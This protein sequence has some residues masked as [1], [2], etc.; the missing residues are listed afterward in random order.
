MTVFH[1]YQMKPLQIL[2]LLHIEAWRLF[3]FK[4][5]TYLLIFNFHISYGAEDRGNPK[6]SPHLV[7]SFVRTL[8]KDSTEFVI[9]L[10][11]TL[12][13]S[14]S[15]YVPYLF[16]FSGFWGFISASMFHLHIY[17][18]LVWFR[19]CLNVAVQNLSI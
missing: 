6:R 14:T 13:S 12:C 5:K 8:K 19:S 4:T 2:S 1:N 17:R 7:C 18:I 16:F 9:H 11:L 3:S 15:Y 10:I